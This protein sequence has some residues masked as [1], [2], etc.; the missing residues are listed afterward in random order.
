MSYDMTMRPWQD[1]RMWITLSMLGKVQQGAVNKKENV[2]RVRQEK[3]L[4]LSHSA[5]WDCADLSGLSTSCCSHPSHLA[6]AGQEA[7]KSTEVAHNLLQGFPN[8]QSC[9]G[10]HSPHHCRATVNKNQL[11]TAFTKLSM[12]HIFTVFEHEQLGSLVLCLINITTRWRC[13]VQLCT[14]AREKR[15]VIFKY[16]QK[17]WKLFWYLN[18]T[19]HY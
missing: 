18:G 7:V 2:I 14:Q 9:Q 11:E 5:F 4:I 12:C 15:N 8:N 19:Y 10:L 17:I 6:I 16:S 1:K 13:A 3:E